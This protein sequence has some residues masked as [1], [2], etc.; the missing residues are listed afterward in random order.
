MSAIFTISIDDGNPADVLTSHVLEKHGI[1]GTF[2]IPCRKVMRGA[3]PLDELF[4]L[5]NTHEIG[6][7]GVY[8]I[9]LT[10]LKPIAAREQI[11]DS[12]IYWDELLQKWSNI[13]SYPWGNCNPDVIKLAKKAG[14]EGGR[15][16]DFVKS[17]DTFDSFRM[18][19]SFSFSDGKLLEQKE[20]I[21]HAE[22]VYDEGGVFHI[23]GHSWELRNGDGWSYLDNFLGELLSIGNWKLMTNS[24]VVK[25]R[26]ILD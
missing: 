3:F 22:R 14:Y 6:G 25:A 18:P 2:Y 11:E 16:V 9:D 19:V 26:G 23:F 13:L 17:I 12:K 5:S 4:R 24:E 10:T 21:D 8:H 20:S 15:T 7:H 1:R